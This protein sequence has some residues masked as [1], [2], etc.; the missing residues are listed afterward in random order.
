MMD[1]SGK[2]STIPENYLNTSDKKYEKFPEF[3]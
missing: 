1:N 3:S 2:Y